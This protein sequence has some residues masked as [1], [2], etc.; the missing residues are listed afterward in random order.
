MHWP[1]LAVSDYIALAS[2]LGGALFTIFKFI[3][4][5]RTNDL[6]HLDMKIDVHHKAMSEL[7]NDMK[8]TVEGVDRKLDGHIRDHAMGAFSHHDS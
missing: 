1:T 4:K 3:Q 5:I 2:M 7:V 6:T 8:S